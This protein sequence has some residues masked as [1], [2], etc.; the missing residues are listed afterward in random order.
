MI[1]NEFYQCEHCDFNTES[2]HAICIHYDVAH[3]DREDESMPEFRTDIG[4]AKTGQG[5]TFYEQP[6]GSYTDGDLYFANSNDL[7]LNH[8]HTLVTFCAPL[9]KVR[10]E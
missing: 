1:E 2:E 9:F 5:Y 6:D 3:S 4:W 7:L 10:P 8:R